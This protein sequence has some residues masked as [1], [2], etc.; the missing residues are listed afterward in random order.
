MDNGFLF[1]LEINFWLR[2]SNFK[3][4]N[5]RIITVFVFNPKIYQKKK[6]EVI[7]RGNCTYLILIMGFYFKN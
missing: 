5:L 6:G 3:N 7:K 1:G 4:A 2:R